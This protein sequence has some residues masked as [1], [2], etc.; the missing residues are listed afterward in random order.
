M[1]IGAGALVVGL[2]IYAL[3]DCARTEKVRIKGVS[4]A[5]WILLILVLP[6]LGALLWL[7]LGKER[8]ARTWNEKSAPRSTR[9]TSPDDDEEYLRFLQARVRRQK[10][11]QQHD[12]D[13]DAW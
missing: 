9:P 3:I 6:V 12:E 10:Q 2:I 4:K 13:D 8:V 5:L 7:V 11:S 1:I